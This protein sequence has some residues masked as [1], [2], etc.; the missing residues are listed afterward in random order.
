VSALKPLESVGAI[1]SQAGA[2]LQSWLQNWLYRQSEEA[3]GPTTTTPTTA[4]AT[5][6]T[7]STSHSAAATYGGGTAAA[8]GVMRR[9]DSAIG[10]PTGSSSSAASA[11]AAAATPCRPRISIAAHHALQMKVVDDSSM[12]SS[13][14]PP[15]SNVISI[16]EMQVSPTQLSRLPPGQYTVN[17]IDSFIDTIERL[18]GLAPGTSVERRKHDVVN[19]MKTALAAKVSG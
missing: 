1:F 19:Q 4:A 5:T 17:N 12:V 9:R 8:A 18:Q 11:A 13:N 2:A 14:R 15:G 16:S 7:T 10:T 3:D 6:T